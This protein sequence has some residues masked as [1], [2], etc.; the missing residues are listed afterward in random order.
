LPVP[1]I[2]TFVDT[3]AFLPAVT[4]GVTGVVVPDF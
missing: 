1:T 4:D 2:T 3:F